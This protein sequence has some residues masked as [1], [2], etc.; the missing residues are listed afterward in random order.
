LLLVL[1]SACQR[2]PSSGA[3]LTLGPGSTPLPGVTPSVTVN[4]NDNGRAVELNL[5]QYLAVRLGQ[6]Y[7]WRLSVSEPAVLEFTESASESQGQQAILRAAQPGETRLVVD[8]EPTCKR[9]D[10]PCSQPTRA[11]SVSVT[12]H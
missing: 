3:I 5:G 6:D 8:G 1:T 4:R 9:S 10:P 7:D 2:S 12:V 11:F